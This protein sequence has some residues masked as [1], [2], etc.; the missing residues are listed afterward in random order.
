MLQEKVKPKTVFFSI[1]AEPTD[2]GYLTPEI[3]EKAEK[4]FAEAEEAAANDP[5]LLKRVELAHL[6]VLYTRLYFYSTGGRA[7]LTK[8]EM[9]EVLGEFERIIAEHGITRMAEREDLGNIAA[10]IDR[11]KNA[12]EFVADWWV[13]GPFD[14]ED[15]KG[16]IKKYRP[17]EKFDTTDVFQGTG[18]REIKWQ[19]YKNPESGY[20]DFTKIFRYSGKGV[21]YATRVFKMDQDRTIKVGIGSNDGVRMWLNGKLVLDHKVLRKA[22]PNQEILTPP[23][24]KGENTVLIKIDQDGGGWGFYFSFPDQ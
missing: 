4:L 6:P 2:G 10:F 12:P 21:A 24:K 18:K 20:I 11:V 1:Y 13:A 15:G 8:E 17:E 5:A 14:N 16:L 19:H 9:P 3:V 22:E 7:Y 23:F